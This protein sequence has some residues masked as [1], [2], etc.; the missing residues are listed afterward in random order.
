MLL[1]NN[2]FSL[3]SANADKIEHGFFT[4]L[5]GFSKKQFESLNCSFSGGDE[6]KTVLKNREFALKKLKKKKKKINYT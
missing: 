2:Y 5:N 4:R 6:G 3:K 1:N